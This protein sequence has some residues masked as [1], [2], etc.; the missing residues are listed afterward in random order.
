MKIPQPR[1]ARHEPPWGRR[2][3]FHAPLK[4]LDP[5]LAPR[6][7]RGVFSASRRIGCNPFR[8]GLD[9]G[10]GTQGS[11]LRGQPWA[12]GDNPFGIGEQRMPIAG[13]EGG[14]PA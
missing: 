6:N 9:F 13:G 2:Q 11:P 1:V 3:E 10:T 4:G 8:V 7:K 14:G 12:E 5:R